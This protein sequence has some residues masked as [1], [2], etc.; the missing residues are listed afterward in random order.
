MSQSETKQ[1]KVKESRTAGFWFIENVEKPWLGEQSAITVNKVWKRM[2]VE[3]ET[4]LSTVPAP[5]GPA[6]A[7]VCS[8]PSWLRVR[9]LVNGQN[10]YLMGFTGTVGRWGAH[11]SVMW[12]QF[13][14]GP[15]H[16]CAT[17]GEWFYSLDVQV[18]TFVALSEVSL[19]LLHQL[20]TWALTPHVP[21]YSSVGNA[22]LDL[23]DL[24]LMTKSLMSHGCLLWWADT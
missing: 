24:G 23:E 21:W 9:R 4:S 13:P 5:E 20:E 14:A 2:V 1:C 6:G 7:D 12:I 19:L 10:K 15:Q 16:F 8:Q 17:S 22:F 3:Q 11:N 18:Q